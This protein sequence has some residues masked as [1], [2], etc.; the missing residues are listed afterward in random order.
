[1]RRGR[2][3]GVDAGKARVGLA[4]C[5]P[6]GLLA[7]PVE[8]LDRNDVDLM[9]RIAQHVSD[10]D[11]IEVVVGL[12]LNLSGNLTPSTEDALALAREIAARITVPVMLVDE[13][14]TT[15]SAHAALAKTGKKQR[16]TRTVID[17]VAA[18]MVLQHSLDSERASGK[19]A[20]TSIVD[21]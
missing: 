6:D 7:T 14:L 19:P 17:Q 13:R 12:P 9:N 11:V 18:V 1:M 20:G 5:D 16:A 10:F 21:F 3:L 2:R 15:V 8:T 4:V